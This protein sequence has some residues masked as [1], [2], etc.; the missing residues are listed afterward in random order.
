MSLEVPDVGDLSSVPP[1]ASR[2]LAALIRLHRVTG[3]RKVRVV[4]DPET[5]ADLEAYCTTSPAG[6][7]ALGGWELVAAPDQGADQVTL[8]DAEGGWVL[9]TFT[10]QFDVAEAGGRVY[11]GL[12]RS[13]YAI[14]EALD[15]AAELG[16]PM[17]PT[18]L[19]TGGGGVSP[20]A[21]SN[22]AYVAYSD[23][24]EAQPYQG[25]TAPPPVPGA[26]Q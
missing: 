10:P 16:P 8:Y 5:V 3:R 11:E 15:L 20:L 4:L 6:R 18:E 24:G 26:G 17:V 12:R 1:R 21:P 14:S 25:P 9:G 23:T 13:G 22:P 7:P 2:T 19:G